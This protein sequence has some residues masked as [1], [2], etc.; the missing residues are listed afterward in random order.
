MQPPDAGQ[1]ARLHH[2]SSP[3]EVSRY[4]V[5]L[6]VTDFVGRGDI[7]PRY[8]SQLYSVLLQWLALVRC[9]MVAT[10]T[11]PP[12]STLFITPASRPS[13]HPPFTLNHPRT[14]TDSEGFGE[15]RNLEKLDLE[16]CQ[17]LRALPAG[18]HAIDHACFSHQF[19]H[20]SF[21]LNHISPK[22]SES[23]QPLRT[24]TCDAATLWPR[25]R[26]PT[27]SSAKSPP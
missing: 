4:Y 26:G 11:L 9:P 27:P 22:D 1:V 14:R 25:M 18:L 5:H 23:C 12:P 3:D 19:P 8:R 24:S 2:R 10:P 6:F 21:T 20:P 15:L 17:S 7:S 13:P 16:Y